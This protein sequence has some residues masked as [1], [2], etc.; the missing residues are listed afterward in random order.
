M[1]E[2]AKV[3]VKKFKTREFKT[4]QTQKNRFNNHSSSLD[5]ILFLQRTIGNQA[6][7]NLFKS[8]LHNKY[9]LLFIKINFS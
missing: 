9:I 2:R 8:N 6:M 3:A 1:Y 5:Q 4:T 7:E